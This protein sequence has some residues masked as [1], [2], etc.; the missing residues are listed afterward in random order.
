MCLCVGLVTRLRRPPTQLVPNQP[1]L[2]SLFGDK[3]EIDKVDLNLGKE[4]GSGQFGVRGSTGHEV[5][6]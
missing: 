3:Y 2:S 6:C 1:S 4:L 5:P